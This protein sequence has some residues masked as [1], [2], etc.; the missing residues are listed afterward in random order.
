MHGAR[1][2]APNADTAENPCIPPVWVFSGTK[3]GNALAS[4]LSQT[5][6]HIIVSTAT[7][8]GREIA[9]EDLPGITVRSG[10]MG[11]MDAG[12]SW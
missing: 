7:E 12:A 6:Y 1:P 8:Y 5:G 10:R 2:D 11:E 4:R 3:D 9:C